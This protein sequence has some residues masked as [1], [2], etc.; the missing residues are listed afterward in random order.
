MSQDNKF[1]WND[2]DVEFEDDETE[3]PA[4]KPK[5]APGDNEAADKS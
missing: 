3:E 4:E 2:G 5:K 1:A